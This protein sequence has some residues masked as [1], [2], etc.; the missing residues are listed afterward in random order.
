MPIPRPHGE[1]ISPEQRGIIHK[2]ICGDNT[3]DPR[4][5]TELSNAD[6]VRYICG[7]IGYP[8]AIFDLE[9]PFPLEDWMASEDNS[10]MFA[11]LYLSALRFEF[12]ERQLKI[13]KKLEG[14]LFKEVAETEF[15]NFAFRQLLRK[16]TTGNYV[17]DD[18]VLN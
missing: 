13:D 3:P 15:F 2:A 12:Y 17:P 8:Q 10:L 7:V 5:G 11:G 14:A 16:R 9:V 4:F 6:K 1:R 18:R